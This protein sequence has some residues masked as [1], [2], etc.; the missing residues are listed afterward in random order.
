MKVSELIARD[1]FRVAY[2]DYNDVDIKTGYTSDL[3][4]DVMANAD[5]DCALITIQAHKNTV[6]VCSLVSASAVIICNNRPIADDMVDA[7]KKENLAIVVTDK[8]QFE[9]SVILASLLG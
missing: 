5:D 4:S 1:E 6:A 9:T 3:L 7:A 2:E 8:N